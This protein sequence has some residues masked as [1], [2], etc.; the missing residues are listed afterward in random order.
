[1]LGVQLL[2]TQVPPHETW[3]LAFSPVD[4]P[5]SLSQI[6][7]SIRLHCLVIIL[8]APISHWLCLQSRPVIAWTGFAC[9]QPW[10]PMPI[11]CRPHSGFL[12]S[13]ESALTPLPLLYPILLL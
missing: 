2:L 6:P 9:D 12:G 8:F 7:P 1:M 3:N 4:S 10:H 13:V 11:L 5:A